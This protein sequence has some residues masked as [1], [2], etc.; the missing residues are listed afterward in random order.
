MKNAV[1]YI[2][3]SGKGEFNCIVGGGVP[4]AP[5]YCVPLRIGFGRIRNHKPPGRPEAVPYVR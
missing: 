3:Y 2:R 5:R 1:R 4:D